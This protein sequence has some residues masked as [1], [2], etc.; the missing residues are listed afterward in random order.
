MS[1]VALVLI[2][3]RL[4]LILG[5]MVLIGVQFAFFRRFSRVK[6]KHQWAIITFEYYLGST[7]PALWDKKYYLGSVALPFQ[8]GNSLQLV[9]LDDIAVDFDRILLSK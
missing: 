6:T 3:E 7:L 8:S 4:V 1:G 9:V 5:Q 2:R